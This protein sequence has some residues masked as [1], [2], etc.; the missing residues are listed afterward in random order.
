MRRPFIPLSD[1]AYQQM[2]SWQ[3]VGVF[4]LGCM[5]REHLLNLDSAATWWL[6]LSRP[7]R[8]WIAGP[9]RR[10]EVRPEF[11]PQPTQQQKLPDARAARPASTE[12]CRHRLPASSCPA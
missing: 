2:E 7:W 12:L 6:D 10:T 5:E 1:L 9:V 4:A 11:G 8:G 3:R